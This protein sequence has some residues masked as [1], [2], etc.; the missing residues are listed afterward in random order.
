MTKTTKLDVAQFVLKKKLREKPNMFKKEGEPLAEHI[1]S[2]ITGSTN[3][4]TGR[5]ELSDPCKYIKCPGRFQEMPPIHKELDLVLSC[6]MDAK[7]LETG[8]EIAIR[9]KDTRGFTDATTLYKIAK[10]K[11]EDTS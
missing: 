2:W 1:C 11:E 10:R 8:R 7:T 5:S 9:L 6:F 4:K 3:P